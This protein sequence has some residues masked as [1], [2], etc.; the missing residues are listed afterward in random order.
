MAALVQA[1]VVASPTP[2]PREEL[3]NLSTSLRVHQ[4][5]GVTPELNE[6]SQQSDRL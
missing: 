4:N 6:N 1:Y 5:E 3:L 2:E